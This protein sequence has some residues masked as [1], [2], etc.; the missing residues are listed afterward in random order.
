MEANEGLL[1]PKVDEPFALEID[2]GTD[3]YSGIL[4]QERDGSLL[5]IACTSKR[6]PLSNDDVQVEVTI[7]AI[8]LCL[9]SSITFFSLPHWLKCGLCS[10]V[11]PP[12]S[13]RK[14]MAAC[15]VSLL[16]LPSILSYSPLS[17]Y[18]KSVRR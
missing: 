7:R 16:K 4:L 8:V 9:A 15:K 1:I 18:S 6:L 10:L 3:G 11:L 2:V 12:S 14:T 13:R 5:P 17:P